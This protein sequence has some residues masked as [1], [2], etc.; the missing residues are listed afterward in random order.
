VVS[1]NIMR[2]AH[3]EAL[4][5]ALTDE[6]TLAAADVLLL[7]EVDQGMARSGNR[8]VARELAERLGMHFAFGASYL[9][10]EDDVD[11]GGARPEN[12]LALAGNAVLSRLP[13]GRVEN[14]DLPELRDK[15]SSREKRLGKKRALL[16][17]LL[18]P[19]GPLTVAA[20]HL[21]STASPAQRARQ[22]G[23][24]L[25]RADALGCARLLVG[26]DLNTSTYDHSGGAALARDLFHKFFAVGFRRTIERYMT[27]QDHQERPVFAA[28]AAHGLSV[29]GFNDP[30]RGS[31]AYDLNS[32]YAIAKARQAVGP[33]LAS[34][35]R[36][37]LRPW[38]GVVPARL[39]W[40]AGRGL[41]PT[42]ARVVDLPPTAD[43]SP[44]SDH[45][46]I[47]VDLDLGA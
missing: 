21:D 36:Y 16:A 4:C 29:A 26:G 37:K 14:V 17:E 12:S 6:P 20:C 15:F 13:L 41:T 34:L 24:L 40:F 30:G 28:F 23:F 45:S 31:F 11:D 27:P 46:P 19:R 1:W 42:A 2:G 8:L 25:D 10:L 35:L 5:A 47:V 39:D 7:C 33:L 43:G 9:A 38:G 44:I 18:H 22:L 32:P 3:F